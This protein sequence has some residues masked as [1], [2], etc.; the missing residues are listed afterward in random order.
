MLTFPFKKLNE[1]EIQWQFKF[2]PRKKINSQFSQIPTLM[3]SFSAVYDLLK[4]FH[5]F[6]SIAC[7]L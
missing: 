2:F 5:I 1:N 6:T 4:Y 7:D 3:Y